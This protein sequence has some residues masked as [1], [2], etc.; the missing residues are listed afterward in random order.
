M[1]KAALYLLQKYVDCIKN[2][3]DSYTISQFDD[4][5]EPAGPMIREDLIKAGLV[6]E[7]D[8]KLKICP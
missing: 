3:G 7:I 5:W 2:A 4:D 8:G 1:N 6:E